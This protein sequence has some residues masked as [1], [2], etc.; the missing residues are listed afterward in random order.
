MSLALGELERQALCSRIIE[1]EATTKSAASNIRGGWRADNDW[2]PNHCAWLRDRLGLLLA[3]V[4]E[5]RVDPATMRGWAVV[6]RKGTFFARHSHGGAYAWSGILYLDPGGSPSAATLFELD[7]RDPRICERI[8]PV[9]NLV[10]V[11][12]SEMGHSVEVHR[13]DQPRITIAFDVK[14]AVRATR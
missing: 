3:T 4:P 12:P 11:F 9:T 13:G 1:L 5:L 14:Q 8:E 6:A 10:V 2:L 7:P